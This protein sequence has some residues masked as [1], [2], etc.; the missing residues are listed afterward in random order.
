MI[1]LD[2]LTLKS[3][4]ALVEAAQLATKLKNSHIEP[5]HL[6]YAFLNQSDSFI[7]DIFN[8]V[9]TSSKSFTEDLNQVILKFGI[10]E[11]STQKIVPSSALINCF[12]T[13]S[14][15]AEKMSDLYI[16]TEHFLISF[17]KKQTKPISNLIKKYDITLDSILKEIKEVRG[18]NI[19]DNNDPETKYNALKKYS[20]N[21]TEL[22][23]LGKLDPVIGRDE[24]IR[25]VIQVLSRRTKNNP[26]LI[27]EPGVGKTAIAEGLALRIINNDIPNVLSN[28]KLLSLDMGALVAGAK[29]RGEFEERLKTVIK[30]V[31]QSNGEIILFIDELHTLI[32]AG[33]ADG[34]MDAGQLLKPALARG[35]LR[36][37]GATTLDEYRKYIEKDK[38][39]ERRFQS[40]IVQ[41]PSE[42]DAVTILRGIKNKYEVHHGVRITDSAIVSAVKLS[43]RYITDRFL[44][45]K[46]ID[47]IDEA[48]SRLSIEINSVPSAIDDIRSNITHLQIEAEA[49]K[50]EKDKESK[51]RVTEIDLEISNLKEEEL[52]L[53]TKWDSEKSSINELKN[54]KIEIENIQNE[55]I[56]AEREGRLE[57]VAELKYGMLPKLES[58]IQQLEKSA[59]ER[60]TNNSLL[61]EEVGPE[62]ISIIVSRWTGVPITK[63]LASE[64]EKLIHMEE[65]LN[66]KVIGQSEALSSVSNAIRRSRSGIS[67]PN[68]PIGSFMFLGP[69]GVGKTETVKSLAD[70]LF[71]SDEAIVRIDMSE[72]ME[73]HS[74]SKLIGAPPGYVGYD[75]GGQLTEQVR[76]RPYSVVLLDEIE[77]A[78]PDVFNILLQVLDEGRLTDSQG[79]TVDFK[80][81]IL[82]MTSNIASDAILDKSLGDHKK[83]DLIASALEDHFR[84]EFL[85]RMDDIITFNTLEPEMMSKIVHIQLSQFEKRLNDKGININIDKKAISYLS[86][87]GYDPAYGARPLKRLIQNEV[88]NPIAN[89]VID[90]SLRNG[91]IL[92]ISATDLKLIFTVTD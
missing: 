91:S 46:A 34:A 83:K 35:E 59:S 28:K 4:E 2:K 61:L 60:K 75:E 70:F 43:N 23:E 67:D 9:G 41:E 82:I 49:L 66:Q 32:G 84:P 15:E 65:Q 1:Q 10:V 27:G 56:K 8:R 81:T 90:K 42:A 53:T 17:F 71:N 26:V 51:K 63:M 16:S 72:F 31:S 73:K 21:L 47:L 89:K 50:K 24:E 33:K 7:K 25:R 92:N 57:R 20:R 68:K 19:I 12:N 64:S 78:H 80:N 11:G 74:V 13:A 88:L 85:N 79:R 22:A 52:N 86:K 18:E 55:M 38:A 58:K 40:V 30:E 76:R 44:P 6:F 48:A 14:A 45:D 77:K 5:E 62:E 39:L 87:K 3:Q 37:I 36:C 54:T 69:T 29:Y